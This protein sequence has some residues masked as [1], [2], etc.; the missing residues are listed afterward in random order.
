[1]FWV[2]IPMTPLM[3]RTFEI[4]FPDDLGPLWMN[5]SNLLICLTNTCVNTEFTVKDVTGD[6]LAITDPETAGPKNKNN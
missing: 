1:M 2:R 3:K 6:G 4:E 5:T